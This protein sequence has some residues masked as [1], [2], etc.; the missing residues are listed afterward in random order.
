MQKALDESLSLMAEGFLHELRELFS[1]KSTKEAEAGLDRLLE[2]HEGAIRTEGA[3]RRLAKL[4]KRHRGQLFTYMD[5]GEV[6]RTNNLAEREIRTLH[7][8]EEAH[9]MLQV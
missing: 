5:L 2:K 9:P 7:H 4:L 3:L 6:S 1:L 8:P